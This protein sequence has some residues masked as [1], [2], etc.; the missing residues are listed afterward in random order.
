MKKHYM[1]PEV[2]VVNVE[3][4]AHILD[5]ASPLRSVSSN[6]GLQGG[7]TGSAEAARVKDATEAYDVWQDDWSAE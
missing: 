1:N 3:L 5:G 7:N 2:S 6:V 4:H